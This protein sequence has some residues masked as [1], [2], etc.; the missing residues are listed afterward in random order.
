M[1]Q[2]R[3]KEILNKIKEAKVAVY[4]DFCLDAYWIMDP[5]GSEV[6]VE[7][8]LKAEAVDTHYYSP[9]GA[10][11]IVANLAAL[12]PAVIKAIGVIGDDIY[13]RELTS[14]LKSL[15]AD[16][17]AFVIQKESFST[18]T[19]LKKYRGD[20]E[21]PRNDFGVYN[22]RT[23]QTDELILNNIDNALEEFDVLIFNQQ[24]QG[25]LNNP[26]FIEDANKIFSKYPDKKIIVDSRHYNDQFE[27]VYRKTNDIEIAA[28]C[29][30]HINPSE[31][32]TFSNIRKYG[33]MEFEKTG[34]PVVVT[35][36][37][38]GVIVFDS[39]G[40]HE[41]P[42]IQL[43]TKL[44]TVG[45]GDTGLS[46]LAL[47]L[48]VGIS[49][50]EAAEFG[51]FASAVTV[52]KLFETG[53]ANAREIEEISTDPNFVFNADLAEN[54]REAEYLEDSEIEICDRNALDI[55]GDI[56][57]AV[58]DHDGTI[59]TLRQGWEEIM[60]PMM[61]RSILGDQYDS[62][63][64]ASYNDVVKQVRDFINKTTGI[65]TIFQMEGLIRMVEEF[66]FVPNE[67]VLDK[68]EYKEIYNQDLMKMVNHRLTKLQAGEL[69]AEDFML[70][71]ALNFLTELKKRNVTMYL[72]SG[73]D[74][75][76]VKNEASILGYGHMFDGGIY[77]ALRDVEKF[78][79]KMVIDKIIR[80]N[81]LKGNE[82]AVFG[83]GP[84]EVR[85]GRRFGGISV[86]ITSNEIRRY[87]IDMSKRPRLVKAGAQFLI[88]DF[89]QHQRLIKLL[90]NES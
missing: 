21:D 41:I 84:V 42:G 72:A 18:Y 22:K 44:D 24:V 60:E 39:E 30:E 55:L 53:T 48:S 9:G 1:D 15:H 29:G 64:Q 34:K 23:L 71:G 78:S 12:N 13:G 74:V 52:Q 49:P 59:S 50:K 51:N 31:T 32:I 6:S 37:S 56:K 88:S 25:S 17:T 35:C 20:I 40:V 80:E 87:G 8:G 66:G 4:G 26:T 7:T 89:S 76:D 58:F 3:I 61:I 33:A 57:H 45:A 63:D 85:E 79:K 10:A 16:T 43:N 65:Q 86:G 38:R 46:A 69:D 68:F 70:K 82:L 47:C 19:Y 90:F 62:V 11:N 54:F 27:H 5:R 75:D 81:N 83:D 36:G 77:G 28:L 67:K 2:Q 73:T 14:L